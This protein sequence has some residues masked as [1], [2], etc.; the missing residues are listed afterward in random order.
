MTP[1]KSIVCKKL[2]RVD[3]LKTETTVH[4]MLNC[5]E[6]GSQQHEE[7]GN[8]AKVEKVHFKLTHT[9][10]AVFSQ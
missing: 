2:Q 7:S 5:I 8:K 6:A 9:L 4:Q 10:L 1:Y 3:E